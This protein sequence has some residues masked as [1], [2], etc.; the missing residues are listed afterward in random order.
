MDT[1]KK[2]HASTWI[3]SFEAHFYFLEF[4]SESDQD[5]VVNIMSFF[6]NHILLTHKNN[7][8]PNEVNNA[9]LK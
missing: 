9:L 8:R 2:K 5:N 7:A 4:F 1:I 6:F 3:K